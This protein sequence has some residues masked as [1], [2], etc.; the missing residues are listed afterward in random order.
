MLAER[1]LDM[2]QFVCCGGR[3]GV[4]HDGSFRVLEQMVRGGISPIKEGDCVADPG[5][6][7]G[8]LQ[9]LISRAQWRACRLENLLLAAEQ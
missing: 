5:R 3:G 8:G 7:T 1:G 2:V 9:D 4:H 6:P